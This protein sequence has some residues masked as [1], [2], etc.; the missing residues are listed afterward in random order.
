MANQVFRRDLATEYALQIQVNLRFGE[1]HTVYLSVSA[2]S[3][4][5]VMRGVRVDKVADPGPSGSFL[6]PSVFFA[7]SQEC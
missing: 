7:T 2:G 1:I 5:A 6:R 4:E 3:M